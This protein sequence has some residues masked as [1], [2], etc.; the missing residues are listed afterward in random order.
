ME[1]KSLTFKLQF[2]NKSNGRSGLE[3]INHSFDGIC[4]VAFLG[5]V[6]T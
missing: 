3:C 1:V 6:G 5:A 4:F 2:I